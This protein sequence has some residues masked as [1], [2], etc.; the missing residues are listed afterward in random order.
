LRQFESMTFRLF[1]SRNDSA[2][3]LAAAP[4]VANVSAAPEGDDAV[5]FDLTATGHPEAGVQEVWITYTATRGPLVGKWYSLPLQRSPADA[6]RWTGRLSLRDGSNVTAPSDVRYIVQAVN[7]VG[8]VAMATNLGAYYAPVVEIVS[9]K[10]PKRPTVLDPMDAPVSAKYRDTVDVSARLTSDG[11]PLAGQVVTFTLGAPRPPDGGGPAATDRGLGS[12]RRS[13]VTDG[14]GIAKTALALDEP[15]GRYEVRASFEEGDQLLPTST[16]RSIDIAEQTT[17]LLVDPDSPTSVL[18]RDGFGK[19]GDPGRPL[20]EQ[21][22]LFVAKVGGRA[23]AVAVVTDYAGRATLPAMPLPPGTHSVKA[24]FGGTHELGPGRPTVLPARGYTPSERSMTVTVPGTGPTTTATVSPPANSAGWNSGDVLVTL[25][26]TDGGSGVGIKRVTYHATGA[27]PIVSTTVAG[28]TVSIPITAEGETTVTFFA[29]DNA[30]NDEAPP[31]TVV[32][33]IDRTAP[34]AILRFDPATRDLL[35]VR[36]DDL[37]GVPAGPV[38]PPAVAAGGWDREDDEEE[39]EVGPAELRTYRPTDAA[40]NT[41]TLTVKVRRVGHRLRAR[42]VRLQYEGEAPVAPTRNVV[43]F[44]WADGSD[45]Q[46][47]ELAQRMTIGRGR[48]RHEVEAT[49]D[50]RKNQ[51]TIRLRE[52]GRD[53]RLDRPG[54]VLLRLA[55]DHGGLSIEF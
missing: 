43:R 42:I 12:A 22:V 8:L 49:F 54:I 48:D 7:G 31:K 27:Q 5:A 17:S 32:V 51:T 38:P 3:A 39:P 35:V 37:S 34:E 20:P 1:Y 44:S 41:L 18:L 55:T 28:D 36:R 50:G 47:K 40:G 25:Q 45:Q 14:D 26:A 19:P 9:V 24:Y 4:A 16:T 6:A 11:K 29:T 2:A 52:P 46:L 23:T 15:P 21:N 33:R 53:T 13:A 30:G 10:S